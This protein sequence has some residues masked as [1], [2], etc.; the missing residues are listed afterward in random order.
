MNDRSLYLEAKSLRKVFALRSGLIGG[1]SGEV[2]AVDDVSFTLRQGE[3]LGI[4]GESGSG[5][6]TIA[7]I[8]V[9]LEQLTSGSVSVCGR[10]IGSKLRTAG[11]RRRNAKDIQIVFQ[12]PYRSLDPRQTVLRSV[13]EPL[14]LHTRLSRRARSARA[15]ELLD[16]VG[17]DERVAG[18]RPQRLSGGQRQ[19]VAIARALAVQPRILILDEA[20]ASL[21]VCVQAQVLNLI[22]AT[23]QREGLSLLVITHDLAV[24]NQICESLVVMHAGRLVE[25]GPK[26]EIL[27]APKHPYTRLLRAAVPAPGWTPMRRQDA[28]VAVSDT[29]DA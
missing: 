17:L 11:A 13:E 15:R 27:N 12:N 19:R 14:A 3:S 22:S 2:V 23:R 7:R 16:E 29:G 6:T 1:G 4:V 24:A 26:Q 21:D 5:K 20:V 9:G 28:Q 10:P 25:R 8:L 18:A